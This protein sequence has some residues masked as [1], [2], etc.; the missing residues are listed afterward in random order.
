MMFAVSTVGM[1]LMYLN[2]SP[3]VSVSGIVLIALCY[4]GFLGIFPGIT[5]ENWGATFNGSN[6]G[7]M[8]AAVGIAAVIGPVLAASA[9]Q[10]NAGDY[11]P[12]FFIAAALNIVGLALMLGFQKFQ[13]KKASE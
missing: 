3:V 4:G 5:V 8:F 9:K 7:Y 13:K 2:I 10:A 11:G 12:A 1:L 6:Y